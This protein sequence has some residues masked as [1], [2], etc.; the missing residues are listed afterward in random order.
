MRLANTHGMGIAMV[1]RG[2]DGRGLVLGIWLLGVFVQCLSV[3][4]LL[5]VTVFMG[6]GVAHAQ[7]ASPAAPAAVEVGVVQA[8]S[9]TVPLFRE[10]PSRI[11]AAES[12]E[13]R[14]RVEGFL[15]TI[16]FAEG[17]T[18]KKGDLLFT[19]DPSQFD[20]SVRNAQAALN[21]AKT[22][23]E[24]AKRG[25]EVLKARA[26]LAKSMATWINAQQDAKR[27][28]TLVVNDFVSKQE[29]DQAVTTERESA[30]VVEANKALLTQAEVN[31]DAE[32]ARNQAAVES[33]E[34]QLAQAQLNLSYTKLYAPVSG[35]I[36]TA[37]VKP[38]GLVGRSE[39]TLLATITTIDPIYVVF[40]IDEKDYIQVARRNAERAKQVG[41]EGMPPT[42]Q[43]TLA[44][45]SLYEHGGTLNMVGSTVDA[46]TG[47]LTIRAAFPNPDTLLR[48]GQFA[49]I[50]AEADSLENA[51]TIPQKAVQQLQGM[52]FVYVVKSDSTVEERKVKTSD[53]VG[54]RMV[55]KEGLNAGETVVVDGVQK[56]RPGM[57]VAPK[58][59]S[60]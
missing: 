12:V 38:G 23:L 43:L 3:A 51:V 58:P 21:K 14:A 27:Y 33:A 29:Y 39:S 26:D 40:Q 32:I 35:R 46:S 57:K 44:D 8:A 17:S 25:V 31:Q 54:A 53:R 7:N 4:G 22:D 60:S 9:E 6:T 36:G 37:Q 16:E 5:A 41:Q 59:A 55:I 1:M 24:A 49:R 45:G 30:A 19:I 47:A 28:K 18:V 34:A 11:E 13:I 20:E 2:W 56:L 52:N 42:F 48:D 50:R 10:F 15:A